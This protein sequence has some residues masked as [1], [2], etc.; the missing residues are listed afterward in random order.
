M[1]EKTSH[2]QGGWSLTIR[3]AVKA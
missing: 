1:A 3:V 2:P